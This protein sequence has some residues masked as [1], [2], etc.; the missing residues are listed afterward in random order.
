MRSTRR[1]A[2]LLALSLIGVP[3]GNGG[4]RAA[5]AAENVPPVVRLTA[6]Q[7]RQ[8]LMNLLHISELRRGRNGSDRNDPNY[9]NY[10]ESK[11]SPS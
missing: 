6:E 9:A 3:V 4:F 8:R 7:D 2:C 10:D 5:S 1:P 11:A